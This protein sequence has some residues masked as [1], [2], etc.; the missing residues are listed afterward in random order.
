MFSVLLI[1]FKVYNY[2][3]NSFINILLQAYEIEHNRMI[4]TTQTFKLFDKSRY[5]VNHFDISLAPYLNR[6]L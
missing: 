6:F 3:C 2:I 1:T 5:Y 4:W